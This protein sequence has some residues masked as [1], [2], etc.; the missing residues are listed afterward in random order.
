MQILKSS[1][2]LYLYWIACSLTKI[3]T[4]SALYTKI[5]ITCFVMRKQKEVCNQDDGNVNIAV[6]II[7]NV[8]TGRIV[9]IWQRKA[10]RTKS[11]KTG[12]QSNGTRK[13]PLIRVWAELVVHSSATSRY[14]IIWSNIT[15]LPL[16]SF[17]SYTL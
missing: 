13:I 15:I 1:K 9:I 2:L 14:Y 11:D 10:G 3:N 16:Y 7:Q 4:T 8:A 6:V 17:R 12:V 5:L